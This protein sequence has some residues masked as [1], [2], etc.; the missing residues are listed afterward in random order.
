MSRVLVQ[1][2]KDGLIMVYNFCT[3]RES[4]DVKRA[5]HKE[6]VATRL[7]QHTTQFRETKP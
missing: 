7:R 3:M 1:A 6:H 4:L 5:V 2:Q